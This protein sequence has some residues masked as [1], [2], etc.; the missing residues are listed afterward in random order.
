M[1]KCNRNTN[2]SVATCSSQIPLRTGSNFNVGKELN[3][4]NQ[5]SLFNQLNARDDTDQH[6]NLS[7]SVCE[8]SKARTTADINLD[9]VAEFWDVKGIIKR[10]ERFDFS[11]HVNETMKRKH[12]DEDSLLEIYPKAFMDERHKRH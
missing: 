2:E 8:I 3:I 6:S 7:L 9:K 4:N 11:I 5:S 10:L 1:F 12:N